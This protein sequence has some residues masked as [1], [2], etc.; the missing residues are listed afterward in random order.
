MLVFEAELAFE[1]VLAV[2]RD[3]GLSNNRSPGELK[4][5]LQSI[6]SGFDPDS[7]YSN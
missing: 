1:F 3:F 7:N 2:G 6:R 5:A 4:T